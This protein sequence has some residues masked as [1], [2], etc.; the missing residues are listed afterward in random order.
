MRENKSSEVIQLGSFTRAIVVFIFVL[1]GLA[2]FGGNLHD[3][4]GNFVGL[5]NFMK[6]FHMK[7][8]S[9]ILLLASIFIPVLV[10][11]FFLW[12]KEKPILVALLIYC[13]CNIMKNIL[14][15][16]LYS[17]AEQIG[18]I[19]GVIESEFLYYFE[20]GL[21]SYITKAMSYFIL[22]VF[23]LFFMMD[24]SKFSGI[25]KRFWWMPGVFRYCSGS[26]FMYDLYRRFQDIGYMF[27]YL[28]FDFFRG[29]IQIPMLMIVVACSQVIE[30]FLLGWWL[31]CHS[32]KRLE[33]AK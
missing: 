10:A 16:P 2:V 30:L 28:F 19:I 32:Q 7:G 15:L 14:I 3:R 22:L 26:L 12:G 27:S 13:V 11:I 29:K 8:C 25:V 23:I 33:K 18:H 17:Q 6:F 5:F 21:S 24:N 4:L 9:P 1:D 31:K 20:L